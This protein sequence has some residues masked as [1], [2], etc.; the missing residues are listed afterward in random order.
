MSRDQGLAGIERTYLSGRFTVATYVGRE[1]A[2]WYV[3]PDLSRHM[4]DMRSRMELDQALSEM[5]QLQEVLAQ[6]KSDMA[7]DSDV[8]QHQDCRHPYTVGD[9][10]TGE[11]WCEQCG[12][13]IVFRDQA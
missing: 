2:G 4:G 3:E 5:G 13:Q 8:L 7:D 9:N 11:V 10:A 12:Q 6:A 1:G